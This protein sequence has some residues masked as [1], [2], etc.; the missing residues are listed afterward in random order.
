MVLE[1]NQEEI[2]AGREGLWSCEGGLGQGTSMEMVF[3]PAQSN[4]TR[5]AV[6]LDLFQSPVESGVRPKGFRLLHS[7]GQQN[8]EWYGN[9]IFAQIQVHFTYNL[10]RSSF[11]CTV[12]NIKSKWLRNITI[13][14]EPRKPK[15]T[16]ERLQNVS[17][18]CSAFVGS[19]RSGPTGITWNFHKPP[20]LNDFF[21]IDVHG[22]LAVN[23]T[24]SGIKQGQPVLVR[25]AAS[26]PKHT[27]VA[28][29]PFF[30]CSKPTVG[31]ANKPWKNDAIRTKLL[32][33]ALRACP[34]S[35][36]LG[37]YVPNIYVSYALCSFKSIYIM[38]E[39]QL[40]VRVTS[41][42]AMVRMIIDQALIGVTSG[43]AMVRTTCGH[44]LVK[45]TSGQA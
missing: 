41:G 16:Y 34:C 37:L 14:Y 7:K 31:G 6:L 45:L 27:S 26:R 35:V 15:V 22:R 39:G 32:P 4:Y 42:Q 23:K 12:G 10:Q 3:F 36:F 9:S 40:M 30:D 38:T 28:F 29:G 25:D 2:Y 20:Y 24:P 8:H 43:Q 18:T 17:L 44:A 33:A 1:S 11:L 5:W 21:S 13:F 19:K